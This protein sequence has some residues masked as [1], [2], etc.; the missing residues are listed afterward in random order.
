MNATNEI[1]VRT[2]RLLGDTY[3]IRTVLKEKGWKWNPNAKA[4]EMSDRWEDEAHVIRRVRNYAGVRNR[5]SF[6]VEFVE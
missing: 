3:R 1:Q 5:G 6:T 4:W 2:A